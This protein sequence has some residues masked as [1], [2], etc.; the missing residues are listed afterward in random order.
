M[1]P[2]A[3][4]PRS[5]TGQLSYCTNCRRDYDRRYYAERGG[6]PRRERQRTRKAREREWIE[7]LK[8]G[9]PCADCKGIFPCYVMQWD[10]LPG[11]KKIADIS[12]MA[13]RARELVVA[14]IAKCELVC[15][16]CHAIRTAQRAT[17]RAWVVC[18]ASARYRAVA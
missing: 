17:K 11:R 2:L 10:H 14:E 13:G 12:R 15:A 3:A 18:E 7:S 8:A 5:R 6:P 1:K 4:F 9:V 16:N